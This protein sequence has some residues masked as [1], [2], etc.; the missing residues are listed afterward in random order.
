MLVF[1]A[2]GLLDEI[3]GGKMGLAPEFRKGL[4]TM[5]SLTFST[6][7]LYVFGVSFVQNHMEEIL[8]AGEHMP[9][10]P[11]VIVGCLLAPDMGAL[12]IALRVAADERTAVFAGS[13]IS[14]SLGMT[15]GFQLPVFLAT[16]KKE[17]VPDLM[18]GFIC[19]IIPIP[20]GLLTGG[21][22]IGMSVTEILRNM[23]PVILVCA[24]LI[25]AYLIVPGATKKVLIAFGMMIRVVS[26]ILF[27]I[28]AAGVFMPEIIPVDQSLVS[29]ILVMVLRMMIVAS[30]GLVLSHIVLTKFG[31]VIAK[32]GRLLGVN[33][34][35][36]MG[37]FLSLTQSLAMLPLYSG[38]NRRGQIL[39]A[40]FS[41]AAAY[42]LGGQFAFT[43]SLIPGKWL[44]A[45]MI[46]K[47]L[48]GALGILVA[49]LLLNMQNRGTRP[50][51]THN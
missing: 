15:V 36:V 47:L 35:S 29:E 33:N 7:G 26:G 28:A 31:S 38:M 12:P 21:L 48:N 17:E 10:D 50:A 32:A 6:M 34:E 8:A 11:S 45:Y 19:G 24:V 16:V 25:A 44:S 43:A 37:L 14:G 1:A 13:M 3:T 5:G 20:I 49:V 40:A 41:V 27:A 9:F 39:N 4:G 18:F 23:L 30:G 2:A 22:M 46:S 51:K 42:V